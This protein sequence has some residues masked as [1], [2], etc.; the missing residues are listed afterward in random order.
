MVRSGKNEE[1]VLP[2]L[3]LKL[4]V[5]ITN[6]IMKINIFTHM[7]YTGGTYALDKR[8]LDKNVQ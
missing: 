4:G 7:S 5:K 8:I 2:R 3:K 1:S 6:F